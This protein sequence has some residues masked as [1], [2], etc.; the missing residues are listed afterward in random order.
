M[1]SGAQAACNIPLS[2]SF[3][4]QAFSQWGTVGGVEVNGCEEIALMSHKF[5]R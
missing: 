1:K 3:E 2:P 5:L 4:G